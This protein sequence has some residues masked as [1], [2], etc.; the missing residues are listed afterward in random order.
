VKPVCFP[1][2][3]IVNGIEMR[4]ALRD[5]RVRYTHDHRW[6]GTGGRLSS[7]NGTVENGYS[8]IS[9]T[10]STWGRTRAH[11]VWFRTGSELRS[12]ILIH[13]AYICDVFPTTVSFLSPP[14]CSREKMQ[15]RTKC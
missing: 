15:S 11:R 8:E 6:T 5:R 9:A 13:R 2:I 7:S 12:L 1:K 10:S 3:E 14:L 4:K